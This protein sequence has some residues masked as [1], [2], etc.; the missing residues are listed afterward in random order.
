MVSM[1]IHICFKVINGNIVVLNN[2]PIDKTF[3]KS[4]ESRTKSLYCILLIN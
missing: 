3:I 2:N 1:H 4:K